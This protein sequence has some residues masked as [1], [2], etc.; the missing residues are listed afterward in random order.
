MARSSQRTQPV[1]SMEQPGQSRSRTDGY[2]AVDVSV[3]FS[4][5][6]GPLPVLRD[7]CFNVRPGEV[8]AIVGRSGT[9]KTTLLR[10]LGGLL[11]PSHGAVQLDGQDITGEPGKAISVFQDYK[12][13]LL[14]WRTVARN[15]AFPL[16]GRVEKDERMARVRDALDLVGLSGR[17]GDFPWQLS[18]GMQQRVQ[19]ARALVTRP[20]VLLLDEPF[21]ALDAITKAALQDELL[22][23][24]AR[25]NPTIV[26]ITHDLEE[27]IYLSDR[28]FVISGTPGA[29]TL[30]AE[31]KLPRPRSQV[32][33]PEH[34]RYHELRHELIA[35]LDI[36]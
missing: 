21:G 19:I 3:E 6:T 20:S 10:V 1:P 16:E 34:P 7:V 14:P 27:A 11:K 18:G 29:I 5:A 32:E 9:G 35:A 15:V 28:V 8:V 33:T 23:V 25:T 24:H 26:F 12:N 22:T 2:R 30:Q 4:S 13:A 36:S 31:T 17:E